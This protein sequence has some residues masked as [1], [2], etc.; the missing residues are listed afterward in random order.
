VGKAELQ[1]QEAATLWPAQ[2]Q[3]ADQDKDT[4]SQSHKAR[5]CSASIEGLQ[6]EQ[7]SGG[8][9]SDI[10][11]LWSWDLLCKQEEVR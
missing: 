4:A 10:R 11:K 8:L 1:E 9:G 2:E 5:S 6:G 7:V 3:R